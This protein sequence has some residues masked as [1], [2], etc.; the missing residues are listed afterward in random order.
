M[1]NE[2]LT[3][4]IRVSDLTIDEEGKVTIHDP[5]VARLVAS[6]AAVNEAK[7]TGGTNNCNGGNC[8]RGCGKG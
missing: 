3:I 1:T 8:A 4:A 7:P 6:A 5:D 2:G